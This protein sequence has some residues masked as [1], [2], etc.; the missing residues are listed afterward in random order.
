MK[1]KYLDY[2]L[3]VSGS[4][5]HKLHPSTISGRIWAKIWVVLIR[6]MYAQVIINLIGFVLICYFCHKT[7]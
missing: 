5:G 6:L 7:G 1:P 2:P 3:V 4:I